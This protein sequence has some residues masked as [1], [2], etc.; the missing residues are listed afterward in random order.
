MAAVIATAFARL[1]HVPGASGTPGAP[2]APQPAE[3]TRA[4]QVLLPAILALDRLANRL[5][6]DTVR[7]IGG[8]AG[9]GLAGY[10]H[11]RCRI[12]PADAE[13]SDARGHDRSADD[14]GAGL[15]RAARGGWELIYSTT[16]VPDAGPA[17]A[18]GALVAHDLARRTT[19]SPLGADGPA[20]S[21]SPTPTRELTLAAVDLRAWARATGDHNLIHL[22]PGAA[23][24]AGMQAGEGDVVA[25]GLLL[26][27]ISLSLVPAVGA[28]NLRF[29][30]AVPL[31]ADGSITLHVD[32]AGAVSV[33][34]RTVLVRR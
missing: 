7:G 28:V 24:R 33:G 10:I 6:H 8:A 14:A 32:A 15:R 34:A 2:A 4:A 13:A 22:H 18:R 3:I 21:A 1:P 30:G 25:Q 27:A 26:G 9:P 20:P 29:T 5:A 17:W 11:R 19:P 16:R 12:A 23:L 31:P